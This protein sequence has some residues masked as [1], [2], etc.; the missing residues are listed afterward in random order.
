MPGPEAQSRVQDDDALAVGARAAG[1]SQA[2]QEM[3]SDFDRF[4]MT[5]PGLGPVSSRKRLNH[6]PGLA[7]IKTESPQLFQS[8]CQSKAERAALRGQ[9]FRISRHQ[10][11]ARLL[12]A[13]DRRRLEES[14]FQKTGN[15]L[16]SLPIC[17]NGDLP[18]GRGW[19]FG[20]NYFNPE[21]AF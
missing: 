20:Q 11:G 9:P 7:R 5:F 15:S 21:R 1:S 17:R 2:D 12:I 16:F 6:N 18:H 14:P 19:C 8:V 3:P 13:K 4:E 10:D